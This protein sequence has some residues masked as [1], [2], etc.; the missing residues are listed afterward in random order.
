MQRT[1]NGA[2]VGGS[3]LAAASQDY[4]TEPFILEKTE[5]ALPDND[6]A[7]RYNVAAPISW[8]RSFAFSSGKTSLI[9]FNNIGDGDAEAGI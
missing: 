9:C 7:G 4:M 8:T 5:Y 6:S 3:L 2:S 1:S